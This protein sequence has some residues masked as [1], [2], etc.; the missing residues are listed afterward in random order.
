[1]ANRYAKKTRPD[2]GVFCADCPQFL[3]DILKNTKVGD[4]WGVGKEYEALLEKHGFGTA[5]QLRAAPD[6]WIRKNLSVVGLRMLHELRGISCIPWEEKPASRKNICT[7]RSFGQL[8]REKK[9]IRQA[10]A[11]F[12]ASCAEKLRR[13][14]SCARKIHVFLQTNPHRPADP[15][16]FQSLTMQLPVPSNITTELIRYSMTALDAIFRAGYQYQKAGVIVLDL[17]PHKE[18][19]MGLFD[20]VSREREHKLMEKVDEVNQA[21]GKDLVRLGVH[22]YGN[23]WKLK[24]DHLSSSFTTRFEQLPKAKAG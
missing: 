3:D 1:M 7:S 22:D 20:S 10:V 21:F 5:F 8:I 2:E 12:T 19:Q 17:V 11:K 16:Y 13:E 23:R 24:Q 15:Q 18:V 9:E 6:E 4:I 14:K